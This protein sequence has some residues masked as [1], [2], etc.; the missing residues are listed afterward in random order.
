M[1]LKSFGFCLAINPYGGSLSIYAKDLH[2]E[3]YMN[4][5]VFLDRDGTLIKD[6][7]F[8]KDCSKVDFYA[9]TVPAL[10]LL[11]EHFALFIVTN[12]C[13]IADGITS[14]AEV[15]QVNTHVIDHLTANGIRIVD[16]YVCPHAIGE[17]CECRKP[18]P[19][20]AESAAAEYDLDLSGSYMIGD[21]LSDVKFAEAFGGQGMYVLTGHGLHHYRSLPGSVN[22]CKN[23]L[24]AAHKICQILHKQ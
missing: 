19:F 21:H 1:K 3:C 11:Q 16:C 22:V 14:Q 20:F 13:G 6:N 17:G 18:E 9:S 8:L 2:R 24:S 12:Q 10:K 23:I 4:K 5:A 7:G 15:D